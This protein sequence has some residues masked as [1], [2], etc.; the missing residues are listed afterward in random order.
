MIAGVRVDHRLVHGQVAVAWTHHL[1]IARIILIDDAIAADEFQSQVLK[2][3]KPAGVKL[4]IFSVEKALAKMPK[5]ESLNDRIFIVFG[6]V[7]NALRFVKGYPKLKEINYGGTKKKE[8]TKKYSETIYLT[9]T[10]IEQTRQ[11]LDAGVKVFI[12]QLPS[13]KRVDLT[14]ENL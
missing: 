6:N 4:N 5:V 10:E 11:I 7:D 2:M 14:K 8:G 9:P 13:T 1:D 12:Q 3:A